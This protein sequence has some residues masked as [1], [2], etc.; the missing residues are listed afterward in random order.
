MWNGP[1]PAAGPMQ[2]GG[3]PPPPGYYPP[4]TQQWPGPPPMPP[5]PPPQQQPLGGYPPPEG[6]AWLPQHQQQQQQWG[7]GGRMRA[8]SDEG[9][10]PPRQAFYPPPE[11]PLGP[12]QQQQPPPLPW[13]QQHPPSY[14]PPVNQQF[15][16]QV[17]PM[18]YV[19]GQQQQQQPPPYSQ[20][21]P[22]THPPPPAQ[23]PYG[24]P[25]PQHGGFM[26]PPR[27][28]QQQLQPIPPP[29]PIEEK[30]SKELQAIADN[31][32]LPDTTANLN[33]QL[34]ARYGAIIVSLA[35][36]VPASDDSI[37]DAAAWLL[38]NRQ[39]TSAIAAS[40][41]R[42]MRMPKDG[43]HAM[44][45]LF[46][47]HEVLQQTSG[48]QGV[49]VRVLLKNYLPWMCRAAYGACYNR[50]SRKPGHD[51]TP[52]QKNVTR[53]IQI[54]KDQ[55][56]IT[57]DEARDFDKLATEEHAFAKP[58]PEPPLLLPSMIYGG[59]HGEGSK[60]NGKRHYHYRTPSEKSDPKAA[61]EAAAAAA[62]AKPK[63]PPPL[64]GYYSD[65]PATAENVS[66]G[67]LAS[68]VK[69]SGRRAR[70]QQ[71]AVV[72]YTPLDPVVL[73]MVPQ[74][75]SAEPRPPE[76][77]VALIESLIPLKDDSDLESVS[78][79]S[80][81]P[82]KSRTKSESR[83]TSRS[84]ESA[85]PAKIPRRSNFSDAPPVISDFNI[86]DPVEAFR[87]GRY[88]F[89]LA[90][91]TGVLIMS[92]RQKPKAPA[93]IVEPLEVPSIFGRL[94]GSCP[95]YLRSS[96]ANTKKSEAAMMT[97]AVEE[98]LG[99]AETSC[100][101]WS[102]VEGLQQKFSKGSKSPQLDY[103]VQEPVILKNGVKVHILG[104]V[105]S[106]E[107]SALNV[108]KALEQLQ[109]NCVAL[110]SD[111][112][113]TE[114]RR[115]FQLPFEGKWSALT[116]LKDMGGQGA[117]FEELVNARLVSVSGS[118]ERT[119]FLAACGSVSGMPEL[120]A[121]HETKRRGLPLHS[122]DM[123]ET[124]KLIQNNEMEKAKDTAKRIGDLP[125]SLLRMISD[126]QVLRRVWMD[127][128]EIDLSAAASRG[129]MFKGH[130]TVPQADEVE[131]LRDE[132]LRRI[133]VQKRVQQ[134]DDAGQCWKNVE[135][136]EAEE[137]AQETGGADSAEER[138]AYGVLL[139]EGRIN[140]YPLEIES[141]SGPTDAKTVS[142]CASQDTPPSK[143]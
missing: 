39:Q 15:P 118:A 21:L 20:P 62:K 66:V 116:D 5:P 79:R 88:C 23:I 142:Q 104:V 90:A 40:L 76:R 55:G 4:N 73:A 99:D 56:I 37:R 95:D 105:H 72:P 80:S 133:F 9:Q 11:H 34:A 49:V 85:P 48:P 82:S 130:L 26:P 119:Q 120:T 140:P 86:S 113:R 128:F 122:I 106:S 25:P 141:Q 12:P 125:E 114:A 27:P 81:S 126:E 77:A 129:G 92:P 61:A 117:T 115:K 43:H 83:S 74:Y 10:S 32:H 24:G 8:W 96:K 33:P 2:M 53:L 51:L 63:P 131:Q 84:R 103:C 45:M 6:Q 57:A 30:F 75:L 60:E 17:P 3:G 94:A 31:Y 41:L 65:R 127:V 42:S 36:G 14:M 121:I 143:R 89:L 50:N 101:D 134:W 59:L 54:W 98:I 93:E 19:G 111:L 124:L 52:Q 108:E 22:Y 123:L 70:E 47:I 71:V 100:I 135:M 97:T 67:V 58:P 28:P 1:P 18:P 110:E 29:A 46:V 138:K 87:G 132:L 38:E 16:S 44:S 107:A 69:A 139:L 112:A 137:P 13:Q 109:V 78:S 136:N 7:G 64:Q 91:V 35:G 68:L 102:R